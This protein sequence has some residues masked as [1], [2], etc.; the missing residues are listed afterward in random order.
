MLLR[1]VKITDPASPFHRKTLDVR[2]QSGKI[3][4]LGEG[5]TQEPDEEVFTADNARLSPGFVDIGAY[6]GD[7]GHEEREDIRSLIASARAGGYVA[8]AVLPNT[9]PVRQT[10][11]DVTYLQSR[12]RGAAVTLLPLAALSY[13]AAGKDLT[14]MMELHEAGAVAFTDG[15][16]RSPSGSLLK[17]VLEYARGFDGLIIDTPYDDDLAEEG[18]M[19]EGEISVQLGLRGIPAISETIALR[20]ALS[21]LEYTGGNLL[22]HLISCA[23][24]LGL[25]RE[26]AQTLAGLQGCT[27]GRITLRSPTRTSAISILTSK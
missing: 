14:E 3:T 22:L 18:Q 26:H 10:V 1:S 19:H 7:P 13:D 23:E 8:V 11:A 2:V 24:S 21:I 20:R 25:V 9:T 5:L 12:T 16:G 17:R 4:D 15:P 6:L 27:V